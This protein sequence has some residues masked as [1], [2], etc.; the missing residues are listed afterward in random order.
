MMDDKLKALSD[1]GDKLMDVFLAEAD[2]TQWNGHGQLPCEMDKD[3]RGARNWDMKNANQAGAL[4][5][6]AL[7]LQARLATP[8]MRA[9][10]DPEADIAR[11]EK[12]ARTMIESVRG[13]T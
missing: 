11:F 8:G 9:D 10:D 2:P 6:R 7:D 3:T 4:V 13:K 5:A 1:L 12:Q